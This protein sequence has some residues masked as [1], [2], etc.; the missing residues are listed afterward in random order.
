MP[1]I[2]RIH[3]KGFLQTASTPTFRHRH[4]EAIDQVAATIA[5]YAKSA[6]Q[7]SNT[8]AYNVQGVFV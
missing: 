7:I 8:G 5:A 3:L 4:V 6:K 2:L 1:V